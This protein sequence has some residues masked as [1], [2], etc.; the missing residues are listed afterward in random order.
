MD[1]I[2][3]FQRLIYICSFTFISKILVPTSLYVLEYVPKTEFNTSFPTSFQKCLTLAATNPYFNQ[4]EP[5]KSAGELVKNIIGKGNFDHH[6]VQLISDKFYELINYKGVKVMNKEKMF[7]N[8]H[9]LRSERVVFSEFE[10]FLSSLHIPSY[11]TQ[12]ATFVYQHML[13]KLLQSS[14]KFKTDMLRKTHEPVIVNRELQ[15]KEEQSVRYVA[16]YIL[17][18]IK[19]IVKHKK[20][21]EAKATI[22]ILKSWS[23][24]D[25][26]DSDEDIDKQSLLEYTQ[27]WLSLVNRG[28]L[29]LV[30]DEFYLFIKEIE[31]VVRS[32]FNAEF[33]ATYCGE[34]LRSKLIE[35][36]EYNTSIEMSWE[37]LVKEV[38]HK[39]LAERL[40]MKIFEKWVN[41]RGHAFAKTWVQVLRREAANKKKAIDISKK[42]QPSL[43]STLYS[44]TE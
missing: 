44:K 22:E 32:I 16:G 28:G 7:L 21:L 36:L 31:I 35:K 24:N 25:I 34:D 37:A 41:I 9:K 33:I 10:K 19:K 39:K 38:P 40:K 12:S 23:S 11:S 18:S 3:V 4:A 26:P 5:G 6:F 1:I 14:I 15:I 8:F 13:R 27:K 42:G 17:Y 20:S 30:N 2:I 29:F 43:R